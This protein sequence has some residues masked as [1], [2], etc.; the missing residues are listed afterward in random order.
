M[1]FAPSIN[2]SFSAQLHSWV[3]KKCLFLCIDHEPAN[4]K[5]SLPRTRPSRSSSALSLGRRSKD[6][7]PVAKKK[8]KG[9]NKIL[10]KNNDEEELDEDAFEA[11]FNQFEED[12]KNDGLT[13]DD[14]DD[15]IS[16]EDLARLEHELEEALGGDYLEMFAGNAEN[17]EVD[18]HAEAEDGGDDDDDVESPVELKRWQLR[19]LAV[20]LKA[21]RRKTSIKCLAAELCLDRSI[22][23]E[24]L[25]DPPP[26]LLLMSATLPDE[27]AQVRTVL[28]AETAAIDVAPHET[29]ADAADREPKPT[30][31]APLHVM[32]QRW[33]AQKRVKKVHVQTLERVYRRTKRPTNA[34]ISSI[35]QV[36]NL[37]RKRIVKWFEDRR[38]EDGV[39]KQRVPYQRPVPETFS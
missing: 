15:D 6:D 29:T 3:P 33:S 19:R 34:M 18:D 27:P 20:A 25:R 13:L 16:E 39:P 22:V 12:L 4:L 17:S 30:E 9:R 38:T 23:L 36:T 7:A 2:A 8:K 11:L 26:N 35:V 10:R 24:L 32:Q 21:G 37:P 5:F 14:N 1:A 31:K 28:E